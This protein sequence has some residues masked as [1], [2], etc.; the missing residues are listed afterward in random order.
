LK[1]RKAEAVPIAREERHGRQE[2]ARK[3]MSEN[4]L[5]AILLMEGA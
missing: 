4:A 3:L 2:R 1:S 5:D